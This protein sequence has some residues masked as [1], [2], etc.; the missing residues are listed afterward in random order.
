MFGICTTRTDRATTKMLSPS[1]P[2]L[3]WRWWRINDDSTLQVAA[4][5][6]HWTSRLSGLSLY[7]HTCPRVNIST[8][9]LF[10][11][12]FYLC[13]CRLKLS[14]SLLSWI[15]NDILISEWRNILNRQWYV[16]I[17]YIIYHKY[18]CLSPCSRA[19]TVLCSAL[20][21]IADIIYL[22]HLYNYTGKLSM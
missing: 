16:H 11:R 22:E 21:H 12:F 2:W 19:G 15:I 8:V 10:T 7:T 4:V 14:S 6:G 5:A 13:R 20:E 1:L 3:S 17:S 9:L 18:T